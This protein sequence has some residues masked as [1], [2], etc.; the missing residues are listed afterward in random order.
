MFDMGLW[1][2]LLIGVIALIV[3]GPERL[4]KLA[5]TAGLW[6]GKAR[7]MVASV[8]DE[9]ERELKVEELKRSIREQTDT[10]EFRQLADDVKSI[11]SD[12][13]ST[14]R[15]VRSDIDRGTRQ[16][17]EQVKS[18]STNTEPKPPKETTEST[19]ASPDVVTARTPPAVSSEQASV[20]PVT[21]RSTDESDRPDT[22]STSTQSKPG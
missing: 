15:A 1:E 22:T 4:P 10:E 12:L 16:V 18:P 13:R 3:V 9:V 2:M 19:G 5:R 14:E 11:N 17:G 20:P 7:S 8:R 6:I 21:P